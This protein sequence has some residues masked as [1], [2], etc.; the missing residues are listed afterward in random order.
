LTQRLFDILFEL[1]HSAIIGTIFFY[2]CVQGR[3]LTLNKNDGWS[4][5]TSGLGLLFVGTLFDISDNFQCLE[6]FVILGDTKY[7]AFIEK[8]LGYT[9]GSLLLAIGFWKFLPAVLQLRDSERR[10]SEQTQ[11]LIESEENLKSLNLMLEQKV[12]ERTAGL[13]GAN[14]EL[15]VLNRDLIRRSMSLEEANKQLE[16]FAHTVS[17]DLCAPVRNTGSYA[18][19]L[20]EEHSANMNEEALG[21]A[22]RIVN[23]CD[24]MGELVSALLQMSKVASTPVQKATIQTNNLLTG[25]LIELQGELEGRK[26]NI[27]VSCLPDCQA[28]EV[29]LRQVWVNLLENAIKYTKNCEVSL[30]DLSAAIDGKEIIFTVKDNGSGFDMSQYDKLFSVFQRLHAASEFTGTGI[31]LYIVQNIIRRHGGRVWAES[32]VGDGATFSFTLPASDTEGQP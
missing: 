18:A 12:A 9:C 22:R 25:I 24:Q 3:K 32:A 5:I 16:I 15:A 14:K 26:H 31:G 2:I 30:I 20:L 7:E 21:L 23:K 1:I 13:D 4:L 28:D 10:L 8:V 19:L 17:H 27:V 29:L 6:R 11:K